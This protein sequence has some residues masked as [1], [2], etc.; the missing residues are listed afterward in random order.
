VVCLPGM[1][2]ADQQMGQILQTPRTEIEMGGTRMKTYVQGSAKWVRQQVTQRQQR[3]AAAR[4]KPQRDMHGRKYL[5]PRH[6]G[7]V[8]IKEGDINGKRTIQS[9]IQEHGSGDD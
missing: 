4:P 3:E 7:Y 5:Y 2:R 1:S 6:G 9:H 8:D